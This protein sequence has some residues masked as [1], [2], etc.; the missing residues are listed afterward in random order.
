MLWFAVGKRRKNCGFSGRERGRILGFS[1]WGLQ[2][3]EEGAFWV[4][5]RYLL[6][7]WVRLVLLVFFVCRSWMQLNAKERWWRVVVGSV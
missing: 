2:E 3:E 6:W 7:C 4:F 1:G 5:E